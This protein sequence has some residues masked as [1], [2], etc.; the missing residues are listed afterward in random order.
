MLSR[1]EVVLRHCKK[2]LA[3]V[4]HQDSPYINHLKD[5]KLPSGMEFEDYALFVCKG[6]YKMIQE[7]QLRS[8]NNKTL[9]PPQEIEG[10]DDTDIE[11]V[12]SPS[13]VILCAPM[14]SQYLPP[15]FIVFLLLGPI[16]QEG[17]EQFRSSLL[18][19]GNVPD[20]CMKWRDRRDRKVARVATMP[21]ANTSIVTNGELSVNQQLKFLAIT[22][23]KLMKADRK[24]AWDH[25]MGITELQLKAKQVQQKLDQHW[26]KIIQF[27]ITDSDHP[28]MEELTTLQEKLDEV[29]AVYLEEVRRSKFL[30]MPQ[31]LNE[32]AAESDRMMSGM[33]TPA[34]RVLPDSR[35]MAPTTCKTAPFVVPA[36][37][38]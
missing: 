32:Q 31:R 11:Q 6:I 12:S 13:P 10:D 25:Y 23:V 38:K 30:T 16:V 2:M 17:M 27:N 5:G 9:P 14:P 28:W 34:K 37:A 3:V 24:K 19:T 18:M 26:K 33:C 36:V 20:I 15:G 22:E 29:N 1:A 8:K 21:R 7:E 4:S 35:E